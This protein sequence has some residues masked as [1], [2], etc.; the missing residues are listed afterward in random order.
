MLIVHKPCPAPLF[1]CCPA[2]PFRYFA[3]LETVA[4]IQ[5]EIKQFISRSARPSSVGSQKGKGSK[6]LAFKSSIGKIKEHFGA[7]LG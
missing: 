6:H 3:T 2:T 4:D 7:F 5:Y 1:E